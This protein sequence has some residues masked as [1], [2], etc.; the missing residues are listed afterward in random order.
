MWGMIGSG[1][2]E[3]PDPWRDRPTTVYCSR[4]KGYFSKSTPDGMTYSETLAHT[5]PNEAEGE[6]HVLSVGWVFK[7]YQ[8]TCKACITPERFEL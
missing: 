2:A 8:R 7:S 1:P 3:N 6:A 4:C 5:F